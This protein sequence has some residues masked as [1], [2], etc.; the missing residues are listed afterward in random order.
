MLKKTFLFCVVLFLI[1]GALSFAY[2]EDIAYK[3]GKTESYSMKL[4][5]NPFA[6]SEAVTNTKDLVD[7]RLLGN[8]KS[9]GVQG[10]PCGYLQ[11][12]VFLRPPV[13]RHGPLL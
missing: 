7:A 8:S 10:V 11:T 5:E 13:F 3:N 4:G 12:V 6:P 2:Q 1:I 9:C